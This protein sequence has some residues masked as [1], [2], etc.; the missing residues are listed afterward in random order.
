MTT[1]T[2]PA[3]SHRYTGPTTVWGLSEGAKCELLGKARNAGGAV[4]IRTADGRKWNVPRA[5]VAPL[6]P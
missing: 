4:Q 6:R 1:M 2:N 5:Q 3:M